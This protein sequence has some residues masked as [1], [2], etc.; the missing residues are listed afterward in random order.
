MIIFID[1][2]IFDFFFKSRFIFFKDFGTTT[3]M[4]AY[5]INKI[6]SCSL[7]DGLILFQCLFYFLIMNI[8]YLNFLF[9]D[10]AMNKK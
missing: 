3:E 6:L 7:N 9:I 8:M 1:S 2:M 5:L 10:L 4:R